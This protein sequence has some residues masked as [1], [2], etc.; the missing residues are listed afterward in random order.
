MIC[1]VVSTYNFSSE[2]FS[3]RSQS[4]VAEY[5]QLP[6]PTASQTHLTSGTEDRLVGKS[7]FSSRL[8]SV[9]FVLFLFLLL[10]FFSFFFFFCFVHPNSCNELKVVQCLKLPLMHVKKLQLK[11]PLAR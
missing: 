2:G 9:P 1:N 5:S 8:Q 7:I 4:S 6:F 11:D 10:L 3:G